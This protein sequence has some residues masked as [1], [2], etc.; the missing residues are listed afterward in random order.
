MGTLLLLG[1]GCVSP[2]AS[3]A[4]AATS[5]TAASVLPL[6][7]APLAHPAPSLPSGHYTTSS[8]PVA[9][10]LPKDDTATTDVWQKADG[11]L[12]VQLHTVATNYQPSGSKTFVPIVTT[13]KPAP[14]GTG[15]WQSTAN[16]W[17][18]SFG[19]SVQA[20]PLVQVTG[21]PAPFAFTPLDALPV[22]PLVTGST[23]TYSGIWPDVNATYQVTTQS[24]S[25]ALVLT[26]PAAQTSFDFTLTSGVAA[27]S[28]ATGGLDLTATGQS[29]AT[30]P[31]LTVT[32]AT[33][34]VVPAATAGASQVAVSDASGRAGGG[35]AI[36]I[37]PTW[38]A[39]LR[40]SDFPVTIDPT[41]YLDLTPTT[42]TTA[43]A[44][45]IN[46]ITQIDRTV[47]A[48][49]WSDHS[50][51]WRGFVNFD[52]GSYLDAS[53]PWAVGGAIMKLDPL[54]GSAS[55]TTPL[56][57]YL[58][59]GREHW[60]T[61]TTTCTET[62][63]CKRRPIAWS[64]TTDGTEQLINVTTAVRSIFTNQFHNQFSFGLVG[65]ETGLVTTFKIYG[66]RTRVDGSFANFANIVLLVTLIQAPPASHVTSPATGSTIPTATPTL[67]AAPVYTFNFPDIGYEFVLSTQADGD[68]QVI[69]S[70]WINRTD[71]RVPTWTVPA[72][73]LVNGGTY[74]IHVLT[75]DVS[76][77]SPSNDSATSV[78][79]TVTLHLGSGGPSPTDTVGAAPGATT[80]PAAGAPSPS[81]S[82][83]SVTVNLV[84]GDLAFTASTHSVTSLAG[85]VGLTL[86]YNSLGS[87]AHGL[88]GQ[89]YLGSSFASTQLVGQRTDANVD[90]H[91]TTTG[92]PIG[93]ITAE[94]GPYGVR[95]SGSVTVPISTGDQWQFGVVSNGKMAVR[96]GGTLVVTDATG[97]QRGDAGPLY[98]STQT[99]SSGAHSVT[100]KAWG[101][102]FTGTFELWARRVI[103]TK[104]AATWPQ[105]I[106]P[107]T[108]L[109]PENLTLPAGWS[110]SAS[111][112][113]G[114]WTGLTDEGATVV[115][116]AAN[117]ATA[118]FTRTQAGYYQPPPG[119][120]DLSLYL[121]QQ[122]QLQLFTPTDVL[123]TFTTS[124]Q[125]TSVI[126][127][128][129]DRHPAALQYRYTP[130]SLALK[131]IT[132]PVSERSMHLYYGGTSSN[133]PSAAD[134]P[135][136]MLCEIHYWD[137]TQTS[138]SYN[139]T[140]ELIQY[141][142][143]G[144][145]VAD[146]AYTSKGRITTI[147][148]PLANGAIAAGVESD[149]PANGTTSDCETQITYDQ[150]GM[151]TSVTQPAPSSGASRPKRTYTYTATT[152][153]AKVAIA[154]FDP[155]SG[156]AEKVSYDAKQQIVT[157]TTSNGLVTETSWNNDTQPVATIG[158]NGEETTSVYDVEGEV[159]QSYGPAP[160]ACFTA[161]TYLPVSTPPG[162][163]GCGVTVPL[164]QTDYDQGIHGLA[165]TY[166]SN[167]TYT[168]AP[169]SYGTMTSLDGTWPSSL[170]TGTTVHSIQLKGFVHLSQGTQWGFKVSSGSTLT[171]IV[172]GELVIHRIPTTVD[173][174]EYSQTG[175]TIDKTIAPG[176][177][178][179]EIDAN[180]SFDL[181]YE[182]GGSNW[183]QI[184]A[185]ALDPG[186]G[187]KTSVTTPDGDVTDYSYTD[188]ADGIGPQYGLV[189]AT[190]EDPSGL[191]LTTS[192]TYEPPSSSTYLRKTST[193]LPAGGTT[194]DSYYSGTAGPIA[195]VCGVSAT[196]PQGGQLKEQIGPS[197]GTAGKA[198]AQQFV[199]DAAG[200]LL[201]V[202]VGDV[203]DVTSAGWQCTHYDAQG[204]ITS[205][206]W[207]AYDGAAA[208]TVTYTYAVGGNPLVNSVADASG[209]ITSTVDLLGR[210]V[211]Y[212]DASGKT[213]TTT[214][215]QAG[216]V[217]ATT[218]PAG[219]EAESYNATTGQLDTVKL[220]G[221]TEATVTYCTTSES[222][223]TDPC[224]GQAETV[225]YGN[226]TTASYRYDSYGSEV[227][228]SYKKGSTTFAGDEI[229]KS[230]GGRELTDSPFTPTSGTFVNPRSGGGTD[231]TYDGAGRLTQ[232]YITGAKVT[233]SYA[234]NATS[235]G[236][237]DPD[238]GENT[239]RTSVVYYPT[240][241]GTA[242][243]DSCYNGA[244]QLVKTITSGTATT[245]GS[246]TS[247]SYTYDTVGNQT[248]N[249]GTT[250][251]WSSSG[252]MATATSGG[253]T[254]TYTDD[255]VN[256]L[257]KRVGSSTTR[258]AYCGYTTSPCA[259]LNSSG[260]VTQRLIGLPGGVTLTTQ[261]SGNLWSYPNLQG[262]YIA[263]TNQTGVVQGSVVTYDPF[264]EIYPKASAPTNVSGGASLAGFGADG[265]LQENTLSTPIVFMGARAY[266]PSD[267]EFLSV[268]PIEGGCAN[269]YTYVRGDPL[270]S[271]DL[272]GQGGCGTTGILSEVLGV[273]LGAVA[274]AIAVAVFIAEPETALGA[275]LAV[276][277][278]A[279]A[280]V[281]GGAAATLDGRGCF[282][283]GSPF[284]CVGFLMGAGAAAGSGADVVLSGLGKAADSE[285]ASSALKLAAANLGLKSLVVDGTAL[286][287]D[288]S[289]RPCSG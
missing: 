111:N 244:D 149:C 166:W 8:S 12:Q 81:T 280:T 185:T 127:V 165:G 7:S 137:T 143:P 169:A 247:T 142:N 263:T 108:W 286:Y 289:A 17:T 136:G 22:T 162:T 176:T 198:R 54:S 13:L 36:S 201:G 51:A 272:N 60:T 258:Y 117:G 211:S 118:T 115:L 69:N 79:F 141:V 10:A 184:P 167:A 46:P 129:D 177:Y 192:T 89:Y 151:V 273:V 242:K 168:G 121:D 256:R 196:T 264:G 224:A 25:E 66:T 90:A 228:V 64:G 47:V 30:V 255:P 110:L 134:A 284:A 207:P 98:G 209:T 153:T 172:A 20:G 126:T 199:Y 113:Q 32:T 164:T 232:A 215:N 56:T 107:S 5:H 229:T 19:P 26:A 85:P 45:S 67:T 281:I 95:W 97:Q 282:T 120:T 161:S 174:N 152:R 96:V 265:K 193:V 217:T 227:Q 155:S 138:L 15:R 1:S 101:H 276:G 180:G 21:S 31:S 250:Y 260:T 288:A 179:I 278:A 237:T 181:Q 87:D 283:D 119:D 63:G 144:S 170:P 208:R 88:L 77:A 157:E 225:T 226:G 75:A 188:A 6:T 173:K 268:D 148:D 78:Q 175:G 197:P 14:T 279:A 103:G 2:L 145:S 240:A 154:G 243:T 158:P 83:A 274:V 236:C 252:Q 191:D 92:K 100:V 55:G 202:R 130:T 49:G 160:E 221:T 44:G 163:A 189:T 150:S 76:G 37:S 29:I 261:S 42:T 94:S 4:G 186:Y 48:A 18:A 11:A 223:S 140:G 70:G 135:V 72:G 159:T 133:C 206:S 147:R 231:F 183:M 38:L 246:G 86:S 23:A 93:G 65:K 62:S 53:P 109:A 214:Y 257:L 106:V 275:A 259:V 35:I 24:V 194:T 3:V 218:G 28:A 27:Q 213:T 248:K 114:G 222:T 74:Y 123:Y 285:A 131:T 235:D 270:N 203:A 102:E 262:D 84:T 105:Y 267:G 146:F 132:D 204:R 99:L 245:A 269:A 254:V 82:P 234:N 233:Y 171:V 34:A 59:Q 104:P 73:S 277:A 216:Q 220:T 112:L 187:L 238:E 16:S 241:G 182:G 200:A 139:T 251:A 249:R 91:W 124:G 128:A 58:D 190:T 156:Y 39:S 43:S 287:Y 230:P 212:T 219:D 122:G 50:T 239:N 61:I 271:S 178:P 266:S 80:T 205:E 125:V 52:F 57:V 195:A 210:V 71:T 40:L 253:T 41:A 33:G 9:R 68:G 116:T